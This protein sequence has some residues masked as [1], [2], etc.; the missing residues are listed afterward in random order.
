M[1][2]SIVTNQRFT[3]FLASI[4]LLLFSNAA[5]AQVEQRS[6]VS[7]QGTALITKDANS[8]SG[9]LSQHATKSGGFLV[10]YSYRFNRWA[11]VEGNYGY[12]RNT[13]NTIG[14]LGR[15]SVWSDFHEMTGAFVA[16]I[17]VNARGFRPYAL[18][19]AVALIF[20]PT[21]DARRTD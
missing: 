10:G 2:K 18:A 9:S 16:H 1:N 15:S 21:D 14:S 5:I 8:D 17:P 7:L 12:S 3:G 11:G 4:A 19:G 13:L 20:D 6:Q